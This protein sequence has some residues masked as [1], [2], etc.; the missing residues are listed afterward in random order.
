[1][2]SINFVKMRCV[3]RD[4]LPSVLLSMVLLHCT[5]HSQGLG[6]HQLLMPGSEVCAALCAFTGQPWQLLLLFHLGQ[7]GYPLFACWLWGSV[8]REGQVFMSYD[9]VLDYNELSGSVVIC[10]LAQHLLQPDR[11]PATILYSAIV[12][13]S[14]L[15]STGFLDTFEAKIGD[16]ETL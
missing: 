2:V 11:C 8:G 10:L 5:A 12:F 16:C 7:L 15:H 4:T 1:M 13:A 3:V 14:W 9:V 6:S